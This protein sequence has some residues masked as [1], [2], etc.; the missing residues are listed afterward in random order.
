[1]YMVGVFVGAALGMLLGYGANGWYERQET[2]ALRITHFGKPAHQRGLIPQ[3]EPH[4]RMKVAGKCLL[5]G[6]VE[7]DAMSD[8][9]SGLNDFLDQHQQSESEASAQRDDATKAIPFFIEVAREAFIDV[10]NVLQRHGR[11]V[12]IRS[13]HDA[14]D[15]FVHLLVTRQETVELDYKI[16]VRMQRNGAI[17]VVLLRSRDRG[18]Q[19]TTGEKWLRGSNNIRELST[20]TKDEIR[21]DVITAYKQSESF[22]RPA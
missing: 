15:P 6:I 11:Y 17:P 16:A 14:A 3:R 8:W 1:M 9:E 5:I 13:N 10:R 18:G 12:E 22:R 7:R 2:H 19:V 20:Y 4:D 21:E